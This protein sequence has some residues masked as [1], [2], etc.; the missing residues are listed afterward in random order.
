M[1]LAA[2]LKEAKD[3]TKPKFEEWLDTLDVEDFDA[4]VDA[5]GTGMSSDVIIVAV[6]AAGG[7]VSRETFN[8]WR[9]TIG[10]AR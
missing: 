6:R 9:R 1:S 4:L 2:Q 3:R 8:A 5:A 10:Q 7:K